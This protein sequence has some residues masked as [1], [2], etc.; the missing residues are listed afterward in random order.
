MYRSKRASHPAQLCASVYV[1]M[2]IQCSQSATLMDTAL[3]GNADT[4]SPLETVGLSGVDM[5]DTGLNA[6]IGAMER[7]ALDNVRFLL[8]YFNPRVTEDGM[9]RFSAAIG[10]GVLPQLEKLAAER[11]AKAAMEEE[12]RGDGAGLAAGGGECRVARRARLGKASEL[13]ERRRLAIVGLDIG[14]RE[15]DGGVGS[16][17]GVSVAAVGGERGGAVGVERVWLV[18]A[19]VDGA[20]ICAQWEACR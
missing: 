12:L 5:G 15:R 13:R 1:H 19:Q 17:E 16:R 11:R 6:L 2:H 9:A 20:R 4:P 8:V 14:G 18:A 7:G 10:A 3:I